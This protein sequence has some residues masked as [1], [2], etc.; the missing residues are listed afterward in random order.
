MNLKNFE[1][2]FSSK[3]RPAE[4]A[5]RIDRSVYRIYIADSPCTSFIVVAQDNSFGNQ[6]DCR[7]GL[8]LSFAELG[9]YLYP[10]A[11]APSFGLVT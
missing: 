9:E 3:Q 1:I 11:S 2:A 8:G 10:Q 5:R 4:I 6:D 7:L